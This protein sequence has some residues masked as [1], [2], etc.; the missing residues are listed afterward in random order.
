MISL[1][2]GECDESVRNAGTV[3]KSLERWKQKSVGRV[4]K[5]F[6]IAMVWFFPICE[7]VWLAYGYENAKACDF[8]YKYLIE[9]L[10]NAS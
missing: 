4:L 1:P 6:N 2:L 7:T 5:P 8:K 10:H 9:Q 3:F